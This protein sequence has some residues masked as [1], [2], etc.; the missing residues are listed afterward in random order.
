MCQQMHSWGLCPRPGS[1]FPFPWASKPVKEL[2]KGQD[3][4]LGADGWREGCILAQGIKPAG[5]VAAASLLGEGQSPAS[6]VIPA[7]PQEGGRR[8]ILEA[9]GQAGT[10]GYSLLSVTGDFTR[11]TPSWAQETAST[12]SRRHSCPRTSPR[13]PPAGEKG[14]NSLLSPL[15]QP[16]GLR[17]DA[18]QGGLPHT[19]AHFVLC[20]LMSLMCSVMGVAMGTPQNSLKALYMSSGFLTITEG[21]F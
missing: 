18:V 10:S 3:W 9:P 21:E 5:P 14:K 15:A 13:E 8:E 19:R 16:S 12:P 6:A 1:V 11:I 7:S 17:K 20:P 4:S 2:S